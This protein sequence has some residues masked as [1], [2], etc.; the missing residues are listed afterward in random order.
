MRKELGIEAG[1]VLVATTEAGRLM[2]ETREAAWARL[3]ALFAGVPHDLHLVDDL[4]AERRDEAL[5]ADSKA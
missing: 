2:L 3:K 4:L 5:R 1:T